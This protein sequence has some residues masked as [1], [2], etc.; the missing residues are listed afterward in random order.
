MPQAG[1]SLLRILCRT[2]AAAIALLRQLLTL[3][4]DVGEVTSHS[5]D[6][7]LALAAKLADTTEH[8]HSCRA[9]CVALARTDLQAT[10]VMWRCLASTRS[11]IKSI[12]STDLAGDSRCPKYQALQGLECGSSFMK[13]QTV[14]VL[15]SFSDQIGTLHDFVTASCLS[16]APDS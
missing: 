13:R 7:T 2:S 16:A 1:R 6:A 9:R 11:A 5:D 4:A 14:Q 15:N 12:V 3:V 8:V 10:D